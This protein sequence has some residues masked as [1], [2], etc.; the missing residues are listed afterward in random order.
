MHKALSPGPKGWSQLVEGFAAGKNSAGSWRRVL[1]TVGI[2]VRASFIL[3]TL[4][5]EPSIH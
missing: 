4:V 2:P 1:V 3:R 5:T